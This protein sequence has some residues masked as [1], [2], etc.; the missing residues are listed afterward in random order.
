MSFQR[1]NTVYDNPI[2]ELEI[3]VAKALERT[4]KKANKWKMIGLIQEI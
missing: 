4:A 1:S 3:K 2:E